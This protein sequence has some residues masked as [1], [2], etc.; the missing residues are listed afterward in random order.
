MNKDKV[1]QWYDWGIWTLDMVVNAVEKGKL[2]ID[3]FLYI[4]GL[5]YEPV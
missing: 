1:K 2:S 5:D 3:D 4:T